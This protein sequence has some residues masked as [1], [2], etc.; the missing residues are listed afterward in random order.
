MSTKRRAR[1]ETLRRRRQRRRCGPGERCDAGERSGSVPVHADRRLR[2]PLQLPHGRARSPGRHGR[3][4]VRPALRL[5]E[6]VRRAARSRRRRLQLRPIR[7]QRPQRPDLRA[8]DQHGG[9]VV[10][11]AHGVGGRARRADD[12][13]AP[14][15]G[16]GHTAH[17]AAVRRG[18]RPRA[19]AHRPLHRGQGRDRPRM[20]ARVRLWPRSR[21][22]D[23]GPRPAS[24][25]RG[26]RRSGLRLQ[27]DMLVGIE[28]GRARARHVLHAG[29]TVYC[30]LAWSD[31]ALVPTTVE[32]PP[33]SSRRPRTSGATGSPARRSP[34]TSSA[35]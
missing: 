16:H 12:G 27:T 5:A 14:R 15:R 11:D 19:R 2:L 13:T 28:A 30:A 23:A 26:G 24:S 8:G 3:L 21:R 6:R 29:E 31:E 10:E 4:A 32:R 33:S 7:D 18:R 20:R 1:L 34:T 17:P 22:V 9:D 35:R 25:R